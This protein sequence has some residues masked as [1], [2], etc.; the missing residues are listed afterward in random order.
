[1]GIHILHNMH[2]FLHCLR[3]NVLGAFFNMD[4]PVGILH[5]RVW[6]SVYISHPTD[7]NNGTI[8]NVQSGFLLNV[9]KIIF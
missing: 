8:A 6:W 5:D 9:I 3:G 7:W 1:M 2:T 4:F